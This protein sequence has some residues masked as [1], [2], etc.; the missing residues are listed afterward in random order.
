MTLPQTPSPPALE[1]KTT[2]LHCIRDLLLILEEDLFADD[3]RHKEA[4]GHF[5]DDTL[6]A[7]RDLWPSSVES[8]VNLGL[9]RAVI[10][11]EHL[12]DSCN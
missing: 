6:L 8:A 2:H 12:G 1:I 11:T 4:L 9:A 7:A 3:L 5:T 10:T